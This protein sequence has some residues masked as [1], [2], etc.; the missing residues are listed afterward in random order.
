MNN[1]QTGY[2]PF[3][4]ISELKRELDGMRGNREISIRELH[5]AVQK[6]SGTMSGMLEVFG[7]AAE[8]MKLEEK[9]SEADAKRNEIIIGKLDRL[10]DQNKT[11]AE[12]M[13]ALV[14]MI[15]GKLVVPTKDREKEGLMPKSKDDDNFFKPQAEK[16]PYEEP[17]QESSPQ[18]DWQQP[19]PE[20]LIQRA[21]PQ[22]PEM[23]QNM[24]PPPMQFPNSSQF[25]GASRPMQPSMMQSPPMMTDFGMQMPQMPPAPL[26]S[27]NDFDFLEEPFPDEQEPKKK[28]LFGMFKK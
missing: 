10:L 5:D 3:K 6:L 21:K 26:A 12:A 23:P 17:R 22:M 19:A 15:K 11:I 4:D 16:M 13:V 18:M 14:D 24:N 20:P 9:E 28:G 8:Q 27:Q 7:A 1:E 2:A 25:P